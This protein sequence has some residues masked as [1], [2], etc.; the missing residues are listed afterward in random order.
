[1]RLAG[2]GHLGEIEGHCEGGWNAEDIVEVTGDRARRDDVCC[3]LQILR[4]WRATVPEWERMEI[5]RDGETLSRRIYWHQGDAQASW[6]SRRHGKR[7][8]NELDQ[9]R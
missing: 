9:G 1:M 6:S 8:E 2:P 7:V 5:F 4:G 3:C